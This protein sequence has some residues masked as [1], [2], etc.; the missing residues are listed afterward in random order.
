MVVAIHSV[1]QFH[2]PPVSSSPDEVMGVPHET[3][4]RPPANRR[5][6]NAGEPDLHPPCMVAL[7]LLPSYSPQRRALRRGSTGVRQ[8]GCGTQVFITGVGQSEPKGA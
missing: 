6:H 7:H 5:G 2:A 4:G 3:R 1:E 8:G